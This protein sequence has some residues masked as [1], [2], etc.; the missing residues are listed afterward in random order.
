M[1][2]RHQRPRVPTS[3]PIRGP[4]VCSIFSDIPNPLNVIRD[5]IS[6][7]GDAFDSTWTWFF[8][9]GEKSADETKTEEPA[10]TDE[11]KE[12][13]ERAKKREELL[14]GGKLDNLDVAKDLADGEG[15]FE[16]PH[17]YDPAGKGIEGDPTKGDRRDEILAGDKDEL[18]SINCG[19]FTSMVLVDAGWDLSQEY[20][21][22]A[23]N[24][25]VAYT[26]KYGELAFVTLYMVANIFWEATAAL[27]GAQDETAEKVEEGS[28][29]AEALGAP[30][31]SFWYSD[32]SAFFENPDLTDD[33]AEAVEHKD[34][35]QF[36][37]GS[38]A[39]ALGGIEVDSKDRKPGDLQQRLAL[40][41][42]GEFAGPG[43][44]SQIWSIEGTGVAEL[45]AT[46]SPEIKGDAGKDLVGWHAITGGARMIIGP[47]TDPS[48]VAAVE[49][50]EFQLI[51]ANQVNSRNS[52]GEKRTG[53]AIDIGQ[54]KSDDANAAYSIGR[55]PTSQ[56]IAWA[57]TE[58]E[59]KGT[60]E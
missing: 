41:G 7:I 46:G 8:G 11:A 5:G 1:L 9:D 12:L 28:E 42:D 39:I 48:K 59:L 31:R 14:E 6:A 43:H 18:K 13:A 53:D 30:G 17:N 37:A 22:P 33:N 50:T 51:D 20:I 56:W 2:A 55:L 58:P 26:D 57:P 15:K 52:E 23:S 29:R 21:D 45:G 40:D 44:S 10:E 27:L 25:P 35:H 54:F 34:S 60:L 16:V 32:S 47:D 3:R 19:E 24:L 38:V 4:A 49:T 36:G